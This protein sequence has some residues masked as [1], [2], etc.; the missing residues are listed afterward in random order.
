MENNVD[1]MI[2]YLFDGI[3]TCCSIISAGITRVLDVSAV[4]GHRRAT[5]ADGLETAHSKSWSAIAKL[6]SSLAGAL[7]RSE[8]CAE[9]A[10]GSG[11][12]LVLEG[13][14]IEDGEATFSPALWVLWPRPSTLDGRGHGQGHGE[15]Y[16]GLGE[17]PFFCWLDRWLQVWGA[18]DP[19]FEGVTEYLKGISE[20]KTPVINI[21]N[22]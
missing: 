15:N 12:L 16:K 8:A 21:G 2:S 5:S 3:L 18:R 20:C 11:A 10:V 17:H 9:K 1:H 19:D 4:V 22:K 7:G 13:H 6:V 14:H